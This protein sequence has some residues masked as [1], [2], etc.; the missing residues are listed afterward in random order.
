MA[1]KFPLKKNGRYFN[2][3]YHK[4][5]SLLFGTIPSFV[6]S[7]LYRTDRLPK[8]RYPWFAYCLPKRTSMT[9]IITWIGHSTFLIQM[10]GVN[11]ITD[12]IFGDLSFFYKR[13][14]PP[15]IMLDKLPPIDCV[16]ISHNHRDHMD[17]KSLRYFLRY[18]QVHILVPEG[19]K[20][21]FEKRGF[22]N[23]IEF[24]WWDK[25]TL[26]GIGLYASAD[27]HFTF[28][29]ADHW[30]QRGLF[31]QNK[32][33]WGSWHIEWEKRFIYFAGDTAYSS[34]FAA[35]GKEFP[36]IDVAL[37]PIGPCEPRSWM[38]H[39]H[40][41]AIEAIQGFLD[42]GARHFIPMHWGTFSLGMDEYDRPIN[43]L[44]EEWERRLPDMEIEQTLRPLKMGQQI[45]LEKDLDGLPPI[46]IIFT[47]RKEDQEAAP[48][49]K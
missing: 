22:K 13:V 49:K 28:L 11:I 21:W 10:G 40:V 23:V 4:P 5:E 47:K 36:G 29:P 25:V 41:D 31:D 17:E 9:P 1:K 34:H 27:I 24:N 37:M 33:L 46:E 7:L 44:L 12:P 14:F 20:P 8:E 38:R 2:D 15:G 3:R 16:V 30:S 19:N 26:S 35:I 39:T 6:Q 48:L 42:L 32:T 43:L 45:L 18:P